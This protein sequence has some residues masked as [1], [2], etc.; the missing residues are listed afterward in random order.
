MTTATGQEQPRGQI[1]L[2]VAFG[3]VVLIG[4]AAIAIDLGFSWMLRRQEQNAADPAALA[5]ARFISDPDPVSGVQVFDSTQGWDAA[6]A[7]ARANGFFSQSNA[8]CDA[9]LETDGTHMSVNYPP[10][11]SAGDFA[12]QPGM[13]QVVISSR[14]DLFFGRIFGRDEATVTTGAVA[15]R[16]RGNTNSNSLVALKPEGCGTARTHG[17]GTIQIFPAAGYS[18]PGGFV[19]I[20][21]ECG[22]STA[23]DNCTTSSQG[24]LEVG[25]TSLLSA[26]KVNVHGGCKG[27]EP[28]C[29]DPVFGA[30][31]DSTTGPLNEAS[32]QLGD[33]LG[34]L[35]FPAWDISLDG[36]KCGATGAAT[37]SG[38][39]QGCGQGMGRIP[40]AASPDSACPG[41][42]G[43]YTCVELNPGVYYGGWSIGSKIVVS[44]KPGI[45]VIAGGGISIG[46]T[47]ELNSL[48]GGSSPAPVLIY[49]TDNPAY[50]DSCPGAGAKRCQGSLDLTASANLKLAGLLA[51][52]PCPPVTSTGGCPFGGMVIWYDANGSQPTNSGSNCSGGQCIDIEGEANLSISGTIYAPRAHVNI[53]GNANTN[54]GSTATQVAAVQIISWTWDLGG[55]GDLC[56]PYNPNQLYKLASQGLVD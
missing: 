49:N 1:L 2:I 41:L 30:V 53:E 45:Y 16:Q 5:A 9:S 37:T 52:Q 54:C 44:L 40:W 43:G 31:C 56:M 14:H 8:D 7:Y 6:C 11:G 26:P 36:A 42:P 38:A 25:G 12:G 33:P 13:V 28:T 22:S 3:M 39:S 48:A 23:D 15:S 19:H 27:S 20:N 47:G 21:S 10:D 46:S 18:G 17:T 24:A 51:D 4:I 34:G 50:A 35:R 55:T 29:P 32:H